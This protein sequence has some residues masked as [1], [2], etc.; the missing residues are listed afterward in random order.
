MSLI[1]AQHIRDLLYFH[2]SVNFQKFNEMFLTSPLL[3]PL[4]G[5][6]GISQAQ[7]YILCLQQLSAR[8][9]LDII[10][11]ISLGQL[12]C[13]ISRSR[14]R[15]I[16]RDLTK[17]IPDSFILLRIHNTPLRISDHLRNHC[18]RKANKAHSRYS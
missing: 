10:D 6:A 4:V 16:R 13:I 11:G 12:C 2:K 18:Y 3:S 14:H 1:D 5:C 8:S 9:I 17:R 15:C 7:C